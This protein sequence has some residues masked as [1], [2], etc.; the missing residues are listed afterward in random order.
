[1]DAASPVSI[2]QS[3]GHLTRESPGCG[4]RR[5]DLRHP[6]GGARICPEPTPWRYKGILKIGVGVGII[7]PHDTWVRE[8]AGGPRFEQKAALKLVLFPVVETDALQNDLEGDL[9]VQV[10]IVGQVDTAHGTGSQIA[11]NLVASDVFQHFQLHSWLPESR[12]GRDRRMACSQSPILRP[13]TRN[14][15]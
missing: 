5:G 4:D 7:D 12:H 9:A 10:G 2:V 6:A 13:V 15:R 1:M 3:P 14:Q 11:D 8:L